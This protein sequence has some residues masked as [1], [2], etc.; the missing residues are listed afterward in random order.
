MNSTSLLWRRK[1]KSFGAY[2]FLLQ[3]VALALFAIAAFIW[4]GVMI[5]QE[6]FMLKYMIRTLLQFYVVV[7]IAFSIFYRENVR[8]AEN[9][10]FYNAGCSRFQLWGFSFLT[11]AIVSVVLYNLLAIWI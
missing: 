11:A 9:Y 2:F 5:G 8:K 6:G 4:S 10:F 1:L 3:P 7:C